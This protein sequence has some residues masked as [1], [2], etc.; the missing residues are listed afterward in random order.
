MILNGKFTRWLSPIGKASK[1]MK[2]LTPAIEAGGCN[3]KGLPEWA[4]TILAHNGYAVIQIHLGTE[5]LVAS[6]YVVWAEQGSEA[7]WRT[8]MAAHAEIMRPFLGKIP[9]AS[10]IPEKPLAPKWIATLVQHRERHYEIIPHTPRVGSIVTNI[11]LCIIEYYGSMEPKGPKQNSEPDEEYKVMKIFN[12]GEQ[13]VAADYFGSDWENT[14]KYLVT[15]MGGAIRLLWPTCR[16]STIQ[17]M[18]S[19]KEIIVTRGFYEGQ[20]AL[21]ILFD[22]HSGAPFKLLMTESSVVGFFPGDPGDKPWNFVVWMWVNGGPR[23]VFTRMAHW[24]QGTTL[25]YGSASS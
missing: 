21:E 7:A 23:I 24:C 22:D 8:A 25:P 4:I 5:T 17:Q 10:H 15:C 1:T 16:K 13:I 2:D 18:M 3:I 20:E 6:T 14:G 9:E 11:A 12:M 19:A